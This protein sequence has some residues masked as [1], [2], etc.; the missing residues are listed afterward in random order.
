[1][2]LGATSAMVAP[3][4]NTAQRL[5]FAAKRAINR[6]YVADVLNENSTNEQLIVDTMRLDCWTFTEYMLAQAVAGEGIG[7]KPTVQK[8]RYRDG[9]IN[10]YGSR[11]HYFTEW[12]Q[13]A[14]NLDYVQDITCGLGGKV[15]TRP[16]NFMSRNLSKYPLITNQTTQQAISTAEQAITASK[17]YYIPKANIVK[18]EPDLKDGDIVGIT[19]SIDGLDVSH[20]GIVIKKNQQAYFLHASSQH[21]KVMITTETLS[22]YLAKRPKHTGI[23]VLRPI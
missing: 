20:Q 17:R 21:K 13:Q 15:T 2:F 7:I 18:I 14:Q 11:L 12:A 5:V 16:V 3:P 19:T 6:P 22:Q 8:L 4:P 9:Q 23:I 1:M 10:G